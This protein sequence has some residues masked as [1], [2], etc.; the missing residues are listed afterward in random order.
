[1]ESRQRQEGGGHQPRD[2]RLE[3]PEAG[4][5]GEDPPLEPLQG[6]QPWDTLT[7]G[8]QHRGR[9][10]GGNGCLL[11]KPSGLELSLAAFAT[12]LSTTMAW[13]K[14]RC[15]W[16]CESGRETTAWLD[17]S[18]GLRHALPVDSTAAPLGNPEEAVSAGLC[19]LRRKAAPRVSP[20]CALLKTSK[21]T[22]LRWVFAGLCSP[23]LPCGH[24]FHFLIDPFA[25]A[26]G[27]L[28]AK[29]ARRPPSSVRQIFSFAAGCGGEPELLYLH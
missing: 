4:R 13:T 28:G 10:S 11:F 27:G 17:S 5:G 12:D 7:S 25:F 20:E 15:S 24:C 9:G 14:A 6:P 2:G 22:Q 29:P 26:S 21:S 3:P 16:I 18:W 1:M 19:E 23:V 8:V